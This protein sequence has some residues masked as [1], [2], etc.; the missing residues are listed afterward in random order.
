[1]FAG[2]FSG[3]S[4]PAIDASFDF[5]F[6]TA[7]PVVPEDPVTCGNGLLDP[8]EECDDGNT[9]GGDGCAADCTDE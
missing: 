2:N 4:A 6:E 8:G 5:F 7:S 9:S 1:M 3:G